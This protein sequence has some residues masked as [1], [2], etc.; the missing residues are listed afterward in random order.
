MLTLWRT[1]WGN[2][3]RNLDLP[4]DVEAALLKRLTMAKKR[5][6]KDQIDRADRTMNF[7]RNV[8]VHNRDAIDDEDEAFLRLKA[9]EIQEMLRQTKD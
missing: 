3:K 2:F 8:I 1:L 9:D 5:Y 6:D 7:F 4:S